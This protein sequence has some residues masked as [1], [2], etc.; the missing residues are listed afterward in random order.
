MA[1]LIGQHQQTTFVDPQNGQDPIDADQVRTNDNTLRATYNNHD[2]NRSV[3]FQ[4][5]TTGER[6][7]AGNLG[8][9]YLDRTTK[10]I[11]F[12]DGAAWQEVN[13]M[14][15]PAAQ[16]TAGTY[17]GT[18][19]FPTINVSSAFAM[20]AGQASVKYY[21]AGDSGASIAIDWANGQEQ[22]VRLT[23]SAPTITLSNPVAGT[24]YVLH[25]VQ[26]GTGSR[27]MPTITPTPKW[28]SGTTPTLTTTASRKDKLVL[29]Y[30]GTDYEG[31]IMALNLDT[32]N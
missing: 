16:V 5:G 8:A 15:I 27:L 6:P 2:N 20:T 10:K 26:D 9:K 18:H 22:R 32:T 25:L 23:A 19:V 11:Y 13:G 31:I 4:S 29:F 12:D 17:V 30:N 24:Y 3:H 7:A 21:N 14:A 28:D 1:E